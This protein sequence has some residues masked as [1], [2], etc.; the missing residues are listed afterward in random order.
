MDIITLAL[1]KKYTKEKILEA[2]LGKKGDK[3]DPGADGKSAYLYALEA[4]YN[5]T[6]EEFAQ[7]LASTGG[8]SSAEG[9][10]LYRP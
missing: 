7:Q 8:G 1:A 9:A 3:G 4:G 2:S 6:E 5:G 10:V